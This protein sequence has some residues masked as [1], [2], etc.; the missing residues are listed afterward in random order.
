MSVSSTTDLSAPADRD[1]PMPLSTAFRRGLRDVRLLLLVGAAGFPLAAC[2]SAVDRSVAV[3]P[4]P[5]DY[6]V[7]HPVVLAEAP[8]RLDIFF[9]RAS[10]RLE[11]A[12]QRE[13]EV[14]ATDYLA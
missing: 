11:Y 4:I 12:Q 2:G 10:G 13:I 9:V 6:H 14:F 5:T 1:R 3:S 8:H 7:R